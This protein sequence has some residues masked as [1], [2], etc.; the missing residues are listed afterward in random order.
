MNYKNT[1]KRRKQKLKN[2]SR[3]YTK[4][5]FQ[6]K[7]GG[8]NVSKN[9]LS[10]KQ[11]GITETW[12]DSQSIKVAKKNIPERYSIANKSGKI[13]TLEGPVNYEKGY[14]IMTGSKGEQYPILP[15][16]FRSLKNDLGN[17]I[18]IPKPIEK[19]AKI[20]DHDGSVYT[21]WGEKLN[22][23]TNKDFIVR[24]GENDYSVIKLDIF[25]TTYDI[26]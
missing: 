20:A 26:L 11:R 6:K 24:H 7:N 25:K 13:D 23:K 3:K 9:T 8:T 17:G 16:T 18:A 2:N 1:K 10:K 5:I 22:Y 4:N 14:Y 12:F 19:L 21:T 15:D